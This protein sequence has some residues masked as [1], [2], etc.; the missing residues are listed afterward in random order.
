MV[1]VVRL[2]EE[3][4]ALED[5]LPVGPGG[6]E[7]REDVPLL[8]GDDAAQIVVG[9]RLVADEVHPP[10]LDLAVLADVEPDVDRRGAV[11]FDLVGDLRHVEALFDV[12]VLDLLDVL[13]DLGEVEDLVLLDV[14]DLVDLRQRHLVVA[15][16]VDLV[17]GRLFLEDEG[18]RAAGFPP[19]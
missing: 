3:Q 10:H 15:G 19:R 11:A 8:R 16:H 2:D 18:D 12:G 9:H 17:D 1:P 5:V 13:L 4:V 14:E 6:G 7:Q